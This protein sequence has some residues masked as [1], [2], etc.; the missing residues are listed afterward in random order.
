MEDIQ[1]S[2]SVSL[3]MFNLVGYIVSFDNFI[4]NIQI[5]LEECV[6]DKLV[7]ELQENLT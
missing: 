1:A 6:L 5:I 3:K 2:L 7:I 4:S